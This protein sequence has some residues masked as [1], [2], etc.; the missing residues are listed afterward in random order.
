MD[1][2][3]PTQLLVYHNRTATAPKY[4]QNISHKTNVL[5]DLASTEASDD[6]G[7]SNRRGSRQSKR[8]GSR[9]ASGFTTTGSLNGRNSSSGVKWKLVGDENTSLITPIT[10]EQMAN[11]EKLA[12]ETGM[13]EDVLIENAGRQDV[14]NKS[15]TSSW[16]CRNVIGIPGARKIESEE[17]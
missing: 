17:S 3:D 5:D 9:K 13:L 14:F 6:E 10:A 11:A 4:T 8:G 15:N 16:N 2:T 12:L 7:I 1:K